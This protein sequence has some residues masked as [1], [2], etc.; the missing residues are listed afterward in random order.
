MWYISKTTNL[1]VSLE[2]YPVYQSPWTLIK[3]FVG[4]PSVCFDSME[5]LHKLETYRKVTD[6]EPFAE[7]LYVLHIH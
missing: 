1:N 4:L 7:E 6:E 5:T 2:I 3:V